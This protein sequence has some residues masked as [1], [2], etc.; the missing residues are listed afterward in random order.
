MARSIYSRLLW[1]YHM[2]KAWVK[3]LYKTIKMELSMSLHWMR[4]GRIIARQRLALKL[5][6]CS[7]AKSSLNLNKCFKTRFKTRLNS[8]NSW[9]CYKTRTANYTNNRSKSLQKSEPDRQPTESVTYHKPNSTVT[10]ISKLALKT[11]HKFASNK[12]KATQGS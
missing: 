8:P 6:T 2:I 11:N 5:K 10:S 9:L 3:W 12:I 1:R 4:R 7:Q